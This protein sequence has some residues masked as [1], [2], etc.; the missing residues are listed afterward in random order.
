MLFNVS[1]LEPNL[2]EN[3]WMGHMSYWLTGPACCW[4]E[5][6]IAVKTPMPQVVCFIQQHAQA[7]LPTLE[8]EKPQGGLKPAW[9]LQQL[10]GQ[11]TRRPLQQNTLQINR[12]ASIPELSALEP[13]LV[14][15]KVTNQEGSAPEFPPEA[16]RAPFTSEHFPVVDRTTQRKPPLQSS[17]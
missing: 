13:P 5:Y 14:V 15:I 7:A 8:K 2:A 4:A 16:D 11:P 1:L 17:L 3:V 6:L 10:T 12:T 9:T